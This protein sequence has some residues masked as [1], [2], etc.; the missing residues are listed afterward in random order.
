MSHSGA[1]FESNH[2][3]PQTRSA[4]VAGCGYVGLR[5]AER[6]V[7][8]A[9]ET[10][11]ITRAASRADDFQS[12]QIHPLLLDLAADGQWPSLPHTD[13]MLWSVGFDRGPGSDRQATWIDGLQRLLTA[14]P[15]SNR[16]RRILYTSSTGVYGDGAGQDV[17]ETTP[18]NPSTEGGA[19]CVAAEKMLERHAQQTGDQVVILRLA[20]IYGPDRLLRRVEEL[21]KGT[22]LTSSPDEWLNLIH[23]DD[24]VR[25]IQ[26]CAQSD[27]WPVLKA[28]FSECVSNSTAAVTLNVVAAESVTRRTYYSELARLVDAPAPVFETSPAA[29]GQS[30]SQRGRSGNRRVVSRVRR[31]VPVHFQ[32]DDCSAGLADAVARSRW[33]S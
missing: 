16:P 15:P 7:A 9:V 26:W 21:R 1:V 18:V 24:I 32:F 10:F 20:G 8:D 31:R 2:P 28:A 11:A 29:I 25:M 30:A 22:P 4:L 3:R 27:S 14:L 23:V 5:A 33:P 19:A 13:V 6:W 12:R 17:D